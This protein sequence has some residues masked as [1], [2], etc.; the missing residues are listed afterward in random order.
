MRQSQSTKVNMNPI[1]IFPWNEHF[2]T[3]IEEIDNQ[4]KRLVQLINLLASHAAF[5][6]DI[7]TLNVIFDE[8]AQY[9]AYHFS[10][11]EAIWQSHFPGQ[12]LV[13]GHQE[14]HVG[15]MDAVAEIK[16]EGREQPVDQVVGNVLGFLTRW[17]A[18]HILD[19]DRYMAYLITAQ[20][21]GKTLAEAEQYAKE[22]L[23]G[24][25]RQLIELI[26]NLYEKLAG[27]TLQLM[28]QLAARR[29]DEDELVKLKLAVEQSPSAIVIT[30]SQGSIE[31]VN[32]AFVE[33][34]GYSRA[35]V[36]GQNPRIF[37][38]GKTPEGVYLEMWQALIRGDVWKGEFVNKRK[39]GSEFTELSVISPI[40]QADGT[41]SHFLA[42]KENI[43][44]R[45]KAEAA[46]QSAALYARSLIEASLDPLVTINIDGKITDVNSAT[47]AVTGV[48]RNVL[49]GSNFADYFT[50]PAMA[51]AGYQLV[52]SQGFVTD[53]PLAIRH[54]SGKITDVLYNASLYRDS[55][56]K[57]LGVFAA[58]RDITERKQIE[59]KLIQSES[60][61]RAIIDNEPECIKI[62][63]EHGLLREMNPAGLA[64]IEAES[65]EQ[66]VG[67]PV[68]NLIAPEFRQAYTQ[69][70]QRV[71]QGEAVRMEYEVVGLK[72]SRRWLETHAVPMREADGRIVHL[73]VTRDISARKQAEQDMRIAAIV[74][75]S[76]EGMMVT[77]SENIILRVNQAFCEITGYSPEEAIGQNPRLL[78]SNRHDADFY[79][80][81]WESVK[82][83]SAW[84]GEIWNRRKNGEIYPEY[85]TIKAVKDNQGRV[86]HYVGT[87]IDITH[88]KAAAEEI[89]RLAF[90]DPLTQLPNRRL[91]QD[92]IKPAL[93]GS[94]RTGRNGAL[95]FI[96]LDNFKGLNDT[97]GHDMGDL[98]LQQ[99]AERLKSCVRED[100]T[101]ARLG[102]D[103]FVVMLEHLSEQGLEA[104]SQA[105]AIAN[106]IL[107]AINRPFQL[108]DHE[109]LCTPSIGA[110][111]FDGREHSPEELLK[112]ADIAMYQAK[113][114]G[115]NAF[116]FFD[117]R[118]QEIVSAR[119]ALE[120]RLRRAL[121]HR[122]FVLYY[123]PQVK[124]D[125]VLL[126]AEV[127]IRWQ[128]PD[129]GLIPPGDFIPLAEETGLIVGI[130]DWVLESA[131]LQ[132]RQWQQSP[133]T[134][135]LL[136]A[137]NVS[138]KQFYQSDFVERVKS[139]VR[140]H[141]VSPDRLKLELTESMLLQD[142]ED[143]IAIMDEL[144]AFGI[145]FSLDDFG[146][147]FSSLQY[148][149]KLPLSQLKID[150]SFIRDIADDGNDEA[151][152]RTII[153]MANTLNLS[154]IAEGV[155]NESQRQLLLNNGCE[156]CQGFLFAKPMPIEDFEQWMR[157]RDG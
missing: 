23:S 94:H 83:T 98:L 37:K 86:S 79:T 115:R 30:N 25:N 127:L 90:Y 109:Y 134:D 120:E 73:A 84:E 28:L 147:G 91:L 3:G 54:A 14:T 60:R 65:L 56:G 148:L 142:I 45:K 48:N 152:V 105:E 125:G 136:L 154:V 67:K 100:D 20:E 39:D 138:A 92:R 35:E 96:D 106:K 26:L 7:P 119:L 107:T 69:L 143:T 157:G 44:E 81:M 17:L 21:A 57:V 62:V 47:E 10:C 118:M 101:V 153:A 29:R 36:I 145:Q 132:L 40:Q 89:E 135:G 97:L 111:L 71:F 9:A 129:L 156:A 128:H 68:V 102:G 76:Q 123:Q 95:L 66:V 117:P 155:E 52:F 64:M 50:D 85:L 103:E 75:E 6:S 144:K 55:D 59:A 130:G 78:R 82:T 5:Q 58:A 4:H 131:C 121:K 63:D 70:L 133:T 93:A 124:S 112:H 72:G 150:R 53:Y 114:S 38:S 12:S 146:T 139:T 41:I 34:T 19:S 99:V 1:D 13:A 74:F 32:R 24:A 80:A 2:E 49:I 87:L 88:R 104:A 113:S 16:Y 116:R 108:L 149:K 151:I 8:L 137:V 77:N 18:S 51:Q 31:F 61:L 110:T 43:S 11:E 33:A 15:F 141:G 140:C 126:G 22:Q 46:R 42:I 122:Q 27:N